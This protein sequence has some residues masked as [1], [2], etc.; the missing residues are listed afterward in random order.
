MI[1][2]FWGVRGSIPSPGPNTVKYGGNTLC[3]ELRLPDQDRL[4]IFDAGSG[5]R[6]LGDSLSAGNGNKG[7]LNAD[8]F[9]THTHLDH[10]LGLPFFAPIHNPGTRLKIYGP[11]TCEEDPLEEVIGGQLSYRYFPIRQHEL[12]ADIEY[13][14]L[15][16]GKY[17]LG[18]GVTLIAKYLN[19]PLLA[20]G[21]RVEYRDKVLCTA[22]DTEP[23][24]NVFCT[25][26]SASSFDE[27]LASE[28]GRAAR[29]ENRRMEEFFKDADLLIHDGQYTQSE[30]ESAKRGWGH[31]P[32]EYVVEAAKRAKVKRLAICHH[33][34]LRTDFQ[35]DELS[36]VY[37]NE[38]YAG[39]MKIFFGREGQEV[40]F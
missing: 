27:A 17:N 2:K 10:I 22:Y 29:E 18:R 14:D 30:Y 11:V 25:D 40:E 23:F 8:I 32:I 24:Y 3:L 31:S 13:I 36:Q 5:I 26:P 20:L 37:G 4:I 12:G 1:L 33:D 38:E 7:C 6:E 39:D 35:L 19:H 21:Y 15:K 28:G 34:P 16:E 9:L